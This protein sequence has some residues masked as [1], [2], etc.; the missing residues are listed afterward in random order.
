MALSGKSALA[1]DLDH[2]SECPTQRDPSEIHDAKAMGG[3][4]LLAVK[5]QRS[6]N[7]EKSHQEEALLETGASSRVIPPSGCQLTFL[8]IGAN[9]GDTINAFLRAADETQPPRILNHWDPMNPTVGDF[10]YGPWVDL[11]EAVFEETGSQPSSY[12]V[13]GIEANKGWSQH[14]KSFQEHHANRSRHLGMHS[15]IALGL[16]DGSIEFQCISPDPANGVWADGQP[17][18]DVSQH[19][20]YPCSVKSRSLP[21]MLKELH[22]QAAKVLILKMDVESKINEVLPEFL[23]SGAIEAL[24]KEG[25]HT[26]MVVDTGHMNEETMELWQA[27]ENTAM[28]TFY[29]LTVQ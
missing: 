19:G 8:D 24:G 17:D 5:S 26:Y 1:R 13:V 9:S 20:Q 7:Q 10:D 28:A 2:F 23:K 4:S 22:G 25:I 11:L 21:S 15:G 18:E 14:Y 27:H 16:T 3:M 6:P 29:D 12:C